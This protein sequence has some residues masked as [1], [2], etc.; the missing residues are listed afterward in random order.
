[1]GLVNSCTA[2][3]STTISKPKKSSPNASVYYRGV[4]TYYSWDSQSWKSSS[5][6]SSLLYKWSYKKDAKYYKPIFYMSTVWYANNKKD[7][8]V[9]IGKEYSKSITKVVNSEIGVST[10]K[11]KVKFATNIS[12]SYSETCSYKTSYST[13]Y[14]FNMKLYS[15]K[16]RY[17]PAAMGN[18]LSYYFVK[19]NRI[20]GKSTTVGECFTFNSKSGCDLRLLYK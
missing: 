11:D 10:T 1:M 12:S 17:R 13:K 8:V 6:N 9:T 16:Y 7:I 19:K 14:T 4:S 15:Q 20:T 2:S 18:I 3:A 5:K